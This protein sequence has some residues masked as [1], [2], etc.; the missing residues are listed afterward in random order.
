MLKPMLEKLV[1][2][3]DFVLAKVDIDQNPDLAN[4]YQV[5][6]V[7]DVRVVTQGEMQSA[8][9]G[10]L[11]EHQI[12]SL[13]AQL[14]LQSDLEVGLQ[15]IQVALQTGDNDRAKQ[16]LYDLQARYPG[17]RQIS[18]MAAKTMMQIDDLDA[19]ETFLQQIQAGDKPYFAQANAMQQLIQ[20][21]RFSLNPVLETE[22]DQRFLDAANSTLAADY[23]SA[24]QYFLEVLTRDKKYRDEAPRKAMVTIFE[25]LGDNHPLVRHY[26]KQMMLALY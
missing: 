13:L 15:Q 25:M 5:E 7:P 4:T 18:L 11:P 20:L 22:L 1:Q 6:G 10:V 14:G 26:R 23:E 12:R 3:Y 16:S 17:D 9:V 24:L 2:E 21:K 8:F 19:A